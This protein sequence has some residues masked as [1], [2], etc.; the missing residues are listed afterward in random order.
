[1]IIENALTERYS[2]GGQL[3]IYK[4]SSTASIFDGAS[5]RAKWYSN[6]NGI[7]YAQVTGINDHA[8]MCKILRNRCNRCIG[9]V[10]VIRENRS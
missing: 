3:H 6:S 9:L 4:W 8:V 5:E 1:M 2:K 10:L 7:D